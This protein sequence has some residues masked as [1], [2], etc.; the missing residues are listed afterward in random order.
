MGAGSADMR[1][2][3]GSGA[4]LTPVDDLTGAVSEMAIYVLMRRGG[5]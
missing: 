3:D 5:T 4:P 2:I 1:E